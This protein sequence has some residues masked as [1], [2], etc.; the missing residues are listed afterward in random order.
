MLECFSGDLSRFVISAATQLCTCPA[1]HPCCPSHCCS[2]YSLEAG[3][4]ALVTWLAAAQKMRGLGL[5]VRD[6]RVNIVLGTLRCA[7]CACC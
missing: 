3:A 1:P 6:A 7:C 5:V 2:G 4:A